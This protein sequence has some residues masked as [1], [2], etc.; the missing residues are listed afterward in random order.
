LLCNNLLGGLVNDGLESKHR[1]R[2]NNSAAD[3]SVVAKM[4]KDGAEEAEASSAEA[5][6][7]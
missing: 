3:S 6:V 4:N 5:Y 7:K 1:S 2:K